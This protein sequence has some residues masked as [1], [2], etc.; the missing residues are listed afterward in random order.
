MGDQAL[1][2]Q[3]L[4]CGIGCT[5][6]LSRSIELLLTMASSHRHG[7]VHPSSA[8]PKEE[9][10]YEPRAQLLW[11]IVGKATSTDWQ[12]PTNR[13]AA[14]TSA[15]LEHTSQSHTSAVGQKPLP[16]SKRNVSTS[17]SSTLC[18]LQEGLE[19]SHLSGQQL[20]KVMG[21]ENPSRWPE[22]PLELV[23]AIASAAADPALLLAL[24]GVCK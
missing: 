22:L 11:S 20:Q 4:C 10:S 8:L 15:T 2:R 21:G 18:S 3:S 17:C 13:Q 6:N 19:A 24:S 23:P 5:I 7:L 1:S 9:E 12:K 14:K 16:A